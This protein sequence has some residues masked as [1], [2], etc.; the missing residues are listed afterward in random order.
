MSKWLWFWVIV[1]AASILVVSIAQSH[2]YGH[3]DLDGWYASLIQPDNG[4]SCCGKADAYYADKTDD[5]VATDALP[6]AL[7][8]IITDERDDGP[9][10]RRHIEPG[11]RVS[12]PPNKIRKPPSQNPT[13]HTIIFVSQGAISNLVYCYEPQ[14]LI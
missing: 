11:T 6:C 9:L 13:G 7:V 5:C 12:I 8:A 4:A 14:P 1:L 3:P 10:Q 2:D